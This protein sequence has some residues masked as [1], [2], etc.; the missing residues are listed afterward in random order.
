MR[1]FYAFAAIAASALAAQAEEIPD[2]FVWLKHIDPTIE[3]DIRY[4]GDHNFLGRPVAGYEAPECIPSRA[5]A[6]ALAAVQA[7]LSQSRLS[8]KVYD[9]Y[10]PQRAVD[11]FVLWSE[12]AADQRMKAEFYPRIDKARFFELGYVAAKSGHTRG[13]TVDAAIVP[14]GDAIQRPYL[15]GGPLVDCALPANQRFP[16]ASLDFGTG[17][18]CMDEKSHHGRADVPKVA[19]LNRLMLKDLMER[20]GFAPY[21]EEWWHYTLRDE[22]FPDTY[23]DFPVVAPQATSK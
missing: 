21:P 5:A 10:R 22:P 15:P 4:Y 17:F 1:L 16:D 3:Q 7:E 23:S 20:H 14:A 9:C 12:D 2:G 6:E 19:Q 13:S 18:D 8:L 11:D